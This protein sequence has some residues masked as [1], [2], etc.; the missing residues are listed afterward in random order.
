VLTEEERRADDC[1]LICISRS[2]T[3]RLVLDL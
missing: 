1:M 2:C 3:D